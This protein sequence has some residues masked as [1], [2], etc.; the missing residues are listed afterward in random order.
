MTFGSGFR[1]Y[2]KT[3]QL[4]R[5]KPSRGKVRNYL[6]MTL[7]YSTPEKVKLFIKDIFIKMLD[8]L[9]YKEQLH[10]I[11]KVSAPAAG[12]LFQVDN[13][14]SKLEQKTADEFHTTVAK[15]LFLVRE[16]DQ[17]FNPPFHS[18]TPLATR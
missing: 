2:T 14:A 4:K 12:R 9:I 13:T 18:Y 11:K 5:L 6:G 7:D 3:H 17:T 15:G 8:E 16:P 1:S 10:L